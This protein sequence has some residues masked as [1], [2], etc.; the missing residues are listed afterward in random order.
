L[1]Y[2]FASQSFSDPMHLRNDEI[3]LRFQTT[4]CEMCRVKV[5]I[6]FSGLDCLVFRVIDC[7]FPGIYG[8]GVKD[9]RLYDF[10]P[11]GFRL[12]LCLGFWA[13]VS[14]IRVKALRMPVRMVAIL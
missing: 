3:T 5:S 14:E 7:R 4:P 1:Q 10:R 9:F 12:R 6:L 2:P 11:K 13:A 8:L